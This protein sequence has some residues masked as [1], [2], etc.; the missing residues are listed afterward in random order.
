M[1]AGNLEGSSCGLFEGAI[2]DFFKIVCWCN[3]N[4][5]FLYSG[6]QEIPGSNLRWF[7]GYTDGFLFLFFSLSKSVPV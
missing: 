5:V 2:L 6:I 1:N 3:N 7:T 4:A